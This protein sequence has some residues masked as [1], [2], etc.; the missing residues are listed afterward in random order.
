VCIQ[1]P[2]VY[3]LSAASTVI[4]NN[5][6]LYACELGV[7]YICTKHNKQMY[8]YSILLCMSA[9][10]ILPFAVQLV[11]SCLNELYYSKIPFYY[12]IIIN[13]ALEVFVYPAHHH[14]S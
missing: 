12:N 2:C 13:S 3:L 7:Q 6:Y 10:C 1:V 14:I 8:V 5:S 4:R 9:L 11:S